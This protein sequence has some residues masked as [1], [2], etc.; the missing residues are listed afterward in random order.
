MEKIIKDEKRVKN[1]T[2]AS[3]YDLT[4][5]NKFATQSL[6]PAILQRLASI[7]LNTDEY[8]S[9]GELLYNDCSWF[10]PGGGSTD[11]TDKFETTYSCDID[12]V[13]L[14]MKSSN[15]QRA[16][17]DDI[18]HQSIMDMIYTD[19]CKVIELSS[20]K[21][22][23]GSLRYEFSREKFELLQKRKG[24][25]LQKATE[26][27]KYI[28]LCT[29]RMIILLPSIRLS[30]LLT[31][32]LPHFLTSSPPHLLISLPPYLLTSY[33]TTGEMGITDWFY[34]PQRWVTQTTTH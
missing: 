20:T 33:S 13:I 30:H 21:N 26:R 27:D 22:K 24:N 23:E 7:D 4:I 6:D 29:L 28:T 1:V 31:S 32:S 16:P 9:L 15:K 8:A 3:A 19:V 18:S 17:W 25:T 10:G 34:P 2:N 5:S 12:Q 14:T 11:T